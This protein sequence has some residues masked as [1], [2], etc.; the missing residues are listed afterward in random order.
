[1]ALVTSPTGSYAMVVMREKDISPS[2]QHLP[3]NNAGGGS[4]DE[5]L[6]GDS[7]GKTRRDEVGRAPDG[8]PKV[9]KGCDDSRRCIS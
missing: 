9:M 1:M 5:E 8:L 3:F 4:A 6:V 7:I 2:L